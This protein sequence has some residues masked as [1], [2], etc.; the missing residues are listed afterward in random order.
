MQ[1]KC[2]GGVFERRSNELIESCVPKIR[3][4]GVRRFQW[5]Y[6]IRRASN[7]QRKLWKEF[8]ASGRTAA[9]IKVRHHELAKRIRAMKYAHLHNREKTVLASGTTKSFFGYVNGRIAAKPDIPNLRRADGSW[10]ATDAEKAELLAE[11]FSSTY[12]ADDGNIPVC[13]QI[14]DTTIDHVDFPIVKILDVLKGLKEDLCSG[15]DALP[16][17]FYKKLSKP[18]APIL[19]F[20]FTALLAMGSVPSS[21]LLANVT[22][23][24]K[25]KGS[26]FQ[27]GNYRDISL[28]AVASKCMETIVRDAL[29]KHLVDVG[30]LSPFQ[31]GF[32]PGRSCLTQMLQCMNDWT[33]LLGK[34]QGVDIMYLDFAKAFNSVSH[35]KLL[36]KLHALGVRGK[37]LRWIQAFLSKRRQ[38]VRVNNSFSDWC[39]LLSG[40]PQGSVLGPILFAIYVNDLPGAVRNSSVRLY[41][42][43]SKL[44]FSVNSV[45]DAAAFQEDLNRIHAWANEWQLTLAFHKCAVLHCGFSNQRFDYTIA[46]VPVAKAASYCDLGITVTPDL[47]PS[48][49]CRT[50]AKCAFTRANLILKAFFTKDPYF[51]MRLFNVFVRPK[52]ECNTPVWSPGYRRDIDVIESVLRNFTSR[53]PGFRVWN[54][55][56]RLITLKQ[57]S[58]ELRRWVFDLCLVYK[59]LGGLI[60]LSR[61]EFFLTDPNPERTRA[62]H[63]RK[64]IRSTDYSVVRSSF[65]SNRVVP[66][67]NGL[68]ESVVSAP[69]LNAFKRRLCECKPYLMTFS[70]TSLL[71][72]SFDFD[73]HDD[74]FVYQ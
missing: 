58:L 7:L 43:D 32:L 64:L 52:L 54:Y 44:Y 71:P 59:I 25:G 67:W 63:S 66:V 41:A 72:P 9:A 11:Q 37:L 13:T 14:S 4:V 23:L 50:L 12:A 36:R 29:I 57:D 22:A 10:A 70:R 39:D 47:K 1:M 8:K 51:F 61:V 18:L 30:L 28:T 38:R 73:D 27:P 16:R 5:P 31:H 17:V 26:R 2:G 6:Q 46:G 55:E 24:Y 42:D 56:E 62:S 68:P 65:F 20:M 35:R 33:R 49:H 53:I 69:S 15:P 45:E 19:W 34:R 74:D 40:V 21:W 60:E 48:V 3:Q